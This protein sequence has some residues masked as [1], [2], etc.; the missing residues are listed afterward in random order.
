MNPTKNRGWTVLILNGTKII[1]HRNRVVHQYT[2][3]SINNIKRR[4]EHFL[5]ENRS[6]HHNTKPKRKEKMNTN[7]NNTCKKTGTGSVLWN[8]KKY[9]LFLCSPLCYSW[10][11]PN[12]K[13]CMKKWPDCN[14]DERDI[15]V[16]ICDADIR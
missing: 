2:K 12:D 16:V 6:I 4:T 11:K 10:Y 5:H 14:Y 8:G 3:I 7:H 1:W 15:Y 9:L 13:A